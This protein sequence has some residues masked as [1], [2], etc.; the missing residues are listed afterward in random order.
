[1]VPLSSVMYPPTNSSI[2]LV[3]QLIWILPAEV[4]KIIIFRTSQVK[5]LELTKTSILSAL[6]L[7]D[8]QE[9]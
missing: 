6:S 5:S 4:T 2:M 9:F 7:D 3:E 8:K 1:M